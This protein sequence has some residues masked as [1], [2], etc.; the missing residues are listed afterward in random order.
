LAGDRGDSEEEEPRKGSFY[1]F[2]ISVGERGGRV[3][4]RNLK[5]VHFTLSDFQISW[6]KIWGSE[7]GE[8]RERI[9]FMLLPDWLVET[10]ESEKEEEHIKYWF[11]DCQVRVGE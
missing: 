4:W 10:W 5:R 8:Q 7:E 3:K 1:T 2:H 11:P 9:Y 6:C